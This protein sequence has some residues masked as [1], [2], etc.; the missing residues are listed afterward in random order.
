MEVPL[1]D[2]DAVQWTAIP[3]PAHYAA[4]G[5]APCCPATQNVGGG[6]TLCEPTSSSPQPHHHNIIWCSIATSF[7]IFFYAVELQAMLIR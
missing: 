2:S 6:Q 4:S 7:P 5:D 1:V 3:V